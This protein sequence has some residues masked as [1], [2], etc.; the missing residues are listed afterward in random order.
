ML[1]LVL[2]RGHVKRRISMATTEYRRGHGTHIFRFDKAQAGMEFWI[3][4]CA[5]MTIK[6][7]LA[8]PV[9]SFRTGEL[10]LIGKTLAKP[11]APKTDHSSPLGVEVRW[12]FQPPT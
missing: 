9:S 6:P 1:T 4:A 12:N 5:G 7:P 10:G 3:P 2:R 11:V 8:M